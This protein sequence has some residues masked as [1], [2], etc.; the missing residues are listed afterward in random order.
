MSDVETR[1]FKHIDK[2]CPYYIRGDE[3][4]SF[5]NKLESAI[6]EI[7]KTEY[8]QKLFDRTD[9]VLVMEMSS[10][11]HHGNN[12][13]SIDGCCDGSI[14]YISGRLWYFDI[15]LVH[16]SGHFNN[17][18]PME[19]YDAEET[20]PLPYRQQPCEIMA[21]GEE[22]KYAGSRPAAIYPRTLEAERER[23]E[24][25]KQ[26]D[27]AKERQKDKAR[28]KEIDESYARMQRD[29]NSSDIFGTGGGK[30]NSELTTDDIAKD[31]S[32]L[33]SQNNYT[34]NS[35]QEI[36]LTNSSQSWGGLFGAVV[37]AWSG[38]NNKNS[39]SQRERK[40]SGNFENPNGNRE[41]LNKSEKV[42]QKSPHLDKNFLTYLA[43]RTD[44]N[45]YRDFEKCKKNPDWF[46]TREIREI[47]ADYYKNKIN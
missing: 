6:K 24:K 1:Y 32:D 45:D 20:R 35:S 12:P 43:D 29:R 17:W 38:A 41:N 7:A 5:Y 42:D 13:G 3:S 8:G 39:E 16:E 33:D 46:K 25:Q 11:Q 28:Q 10:S 40:Q 36:D 18:I 27:E 37:G 2:N 23:E 15:T 30:S 4:Q 31:K 21:Y 47:I 26:E 44:D 19:Y 14:I 9:Y 22:A 34:E